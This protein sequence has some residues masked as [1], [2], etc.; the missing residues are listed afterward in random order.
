MYTHRLC[1]NK[2]FNDLTGILNKLYL[3]ARE[4]PTEL[5]DLGLFGLEK[6]DWEEILAML[7]NVSWVTVK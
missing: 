5:K 2:D 1:S 4:S 6:R 3:S 7:M